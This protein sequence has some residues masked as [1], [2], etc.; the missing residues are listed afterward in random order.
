MQA[1]NLGVGSS[2]LS[3]RAI[4]L[5]AP[6]RGLCALWVAEKVRTPEF[7]QSSRGLR[8]IAG[9]PVNFLILLPARLR[10]LISLSYARDTFGPNVPLVCYLAAGPAL[11]THTR[12]MA[13]NHSGHAQGPSVSIWVVYPTEPTGVMGAFQTLL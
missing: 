6:A 5:K 1:S 10:P 8:D 9:W 4:K 7:A 12:A 13:Q 3:G 11:G 2:N